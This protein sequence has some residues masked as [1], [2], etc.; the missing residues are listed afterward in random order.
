MHIEV[1]FKLSS[2]LRQAEPSLY[3]PNFYYTDL[4]SDQITIFIY[5]CILVFSIHFYILDTLTYL[6]PSIFLTI[7]SL[8]FFSSKLSFVILLLFYQAKRKAMIFRSL[9]RLLCKFYSTIKILG[10]NNT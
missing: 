3:L 6:R 8:S 2:T 5:R 1:V 9:I 4:P 7:L 10:E